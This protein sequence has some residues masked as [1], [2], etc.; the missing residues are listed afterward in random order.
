MKSIKYESLCYARFLVTSLTL[1]GLVN[2]L[3]YYSN[4]LRKK[5]TF[6]FV[7]SLLW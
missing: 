4:L 6:P 7:L 5:G 3:P 1:P 2:N